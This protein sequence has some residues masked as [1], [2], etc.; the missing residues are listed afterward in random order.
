[1]EGECYTIGIDVGGT[2]TDCVVLRGTSVIGWAKRPTS[3]NVTSG[4]SAA[5]SAALQ[6]A[7]TPSG[8]SK[9]ELLGRVVRVNIGTTH[10]VNAVVQRRRLTPVAAIRLCG[11]ASR[12]LPPFVDFPQD[13]A[14][15]IQ[16]SY[17]FLDGGFRFDGKEIVAVNDQQVISCIDNLRQGD[18]PCKNIVIAGL[19]SSLNEEQEKHVAEIIKDRCPDA[20]LTMSH[21]VS[22][23]LV[24]L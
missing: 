23:S 24:T 13:L 6:D 19:F 12:A 17:H 20:S 1:M 3:E 11:P 5:L 4:V 9:A 8:A 2:N 15:E 14:S 10:F 22:P 18:R 7:C 21:Q 16:H